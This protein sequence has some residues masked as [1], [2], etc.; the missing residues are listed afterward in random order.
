MTLESPQ[1][2]PTATSDPRDVAEHR[3]GGEQSGL[4]RGF[5]DLQH[6]NEVV[7]AI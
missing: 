4:G 7:F 6:L 2:L 3:P 5:G 1:V